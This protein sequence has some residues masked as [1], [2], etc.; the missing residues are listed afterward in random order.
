LNKDCQPAPTVRKKR[1]SKKPT[2]SVASVARKTAVLEAKLDDIVQLLE[3]S[4][5]SKSQDG[6][7]TPARYTN[8]AQNPVQYEVTNERDTPSEDV[9]NKNHLP[10]NMAQMPPT[11]ALSCGSIQTQLDPH[12]FPIGI[13][14]SSLPNEYPTESESE[15]EEYLETYRTK[16]VSFLPVVPL[17]PQVTV[18]EMREDRP[19]LWLVIKAICSKNSA[20]Q[21]ALGGE[22]RK[23][24][25]REMLVEG[26]RSL[27]LLLGVLVFAGW[28]HYYICV[29]PL[30]IT[31]D[32]QLG[33]ALASDLG[34][35][36]PVPVEPIGIMLNYTAAGC[37][38]QP[39]SIHCPPR[40]IEE[41]R[42]MLGLFLVSSV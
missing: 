19:F 32:I 17:G 36:K 6:S 42:A 11:P 8:D 25:A 23:V 9:Q 3:L 16:M 1:A 5:T 38:K 34:L 22:V 7:V 31:T 39:A 27:D 28:C 24:L 30:S 33:I 40:T 15:C 26:R 41:R 18:K 14:S 20:R 37:P 12:C 4:Q 13:S 35:T 10:Y 21:R 2:S 29:R